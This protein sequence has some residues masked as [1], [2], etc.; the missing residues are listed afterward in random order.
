MIYA[1]KKPVYA[2]GARNIELCDGACVCLPLC[3]LW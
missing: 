2:V 3:I 1:D